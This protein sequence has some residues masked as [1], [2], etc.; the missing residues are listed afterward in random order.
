MSLHFLLSNV[1][2][3]IDGKKYLA[4]VDTP[5]KKPSFFNRIATTFSWSN[6][7]RPMESTITKNANCSLASVFINIKVAYN[8]NNEVVIGNLAEMEKTMAET[9]N[10]VD[11]LYERY[12]TSPN[13]ASKSRWIA[14]KI[15]S[16]VSTILWI[17]SFGDINWSNPYKKSA[18]DTKKAYEDL[19]KVMTDYV[20]NK[21]IKD[22]R[23]NFVINGG[24]KVAGHVLNQV[25][26][27]KTALQ[28]A[29]MLGKGVNAGRKGNRKEAAQWGACACMNVARGLLMFLI[30][31]DVKNLAS[32]TG[33]IE[34]GMGIAY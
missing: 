12:E 13:R 27:L 23:I 9:I 16:F 31:G 8:N 24:K 25:P 28:T 3:G 34:N 14:S 15:I 18:E 19:K 20:Q 1:D 5:Q 30:P 32:E 2:N 33:K 11:R 10:E 6:Q 21:K 17:I 26:G 7:F 4:F 29:D 22:A